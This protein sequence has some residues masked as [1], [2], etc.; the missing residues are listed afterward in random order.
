MGFALA[1]SLVTFSG[2][3]GQAA[4]GEKLLD[5]AVDTVDDV[6]HSPNF[7][8]AR[9]AM[10]NARAVL[11]VPS[12]V[13]G[14]FIFGAEGGDGVLLA[15]TRRGWSSPA[16]YSLGS[17][18]FGFQAGIQKAQVVMIINSDRA[19]RAL[20]R[21]KFKLGAG[22]GLTVVNLGAG[23]EGATSGNFTGDIIVWSQAEGVYGGISLN[24]SVVA[25]DDR[26][27]RK[28]YGRPV[29][30]EEI[31]ANGVSNPETNRLQ[32]KLANSF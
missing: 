23:V 21:S 10:R 29:G 31:L 16:F 19:L 15:R 14:A 17:G 8:D 6:R 3:V 7:G 32:R 12:L 28:F 25:P 20:E 1:A 18:S 2:S 22:A 30:V 11:I 24:G 13:K 5:R 27:N 4:G 9:R 26:K